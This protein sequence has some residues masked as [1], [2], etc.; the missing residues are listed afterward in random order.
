MQAD[1]VLTML[2]RLELNMLFVL[3]MLSVLNVL[4]V[5]NVLLELVPTAL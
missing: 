5:L 2:L 4:V 3:D 1:A